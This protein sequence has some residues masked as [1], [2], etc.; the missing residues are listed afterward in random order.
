[1]TEDDVARNI[2]KAIRHLV[3]HPPHYYVH[4]SVDASE[5]EDDGPLVELIERAADRVARSFGASCLLVRRA[6]DAD[7]IVAT[8]SVRM[9]V[10]RG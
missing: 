5:Y 8:I 9:E 10:E 1:M 4:V 2:E 7:R 3:E 6:E